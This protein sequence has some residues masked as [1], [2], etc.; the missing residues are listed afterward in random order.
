[1]P[2][3]KR[4]IFSLPPLLALM[5]VLGGA[6]LAVLH[7]VGGQIDLILR[8]NYDSVIAMERLNGAV[9]G[10]D[11]SFQLALAGREEKAG[12][13]YEPNWASYRDALQLEQNN[14]T[15][16]GEAE[17]V[18]RLTAWTEQDRHQ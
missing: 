8:E 15:L 12:R 11:S 7:R 4:I 3:R 1:M 5:L 14:I 10:I 9:A 2:L 6:A 13:Q 16:P 18:E 17:L